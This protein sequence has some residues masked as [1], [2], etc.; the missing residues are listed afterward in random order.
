ML[1]NIKKYISKGWKYIFKTIKIITLIDIF[2]LLGFRSYQPEFRTFGYE[3][4]SYTFRL[5]APLFA[6]WYWVAVVK[7]IKLLINTE[8]K[9][10]ERIIRFGFVAFFIYISIPLGIICTVFACI[11]SYT[12]GGYDECMQ[13]CVNEDQSNFQ[14]CSLSTCD[15]PI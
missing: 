4:F 12:T 10:Y 11:N 9:W 15:F 5:I 13:Q 8:K 7:V 3:V 14:E 6:F 1:Q 2:L